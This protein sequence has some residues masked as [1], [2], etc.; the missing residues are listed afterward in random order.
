MS[1]ALAVTN[2]VTQST[3]APP[4]SV[5]LP[6]PPESVSLPAAA[7]MTS[8]PSPPL[9]RSFSDDPVIVSLPAPPFSVNPA[10]CPIPAAIAPV[11]SSV[12]FPSSPSAKPPFVK[13]PPLN[14]NRSFPAPPNRVKGLAAVT[15]NVSLKPLPCR[16]TNPEKFRKLA[17]PLL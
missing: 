12:S 4:S 6:V 11:P 10:N 16:V 13:R 7:L 2:S 17:E 14:V 3:P 9:S 1:V 15:V 5:L 8:F